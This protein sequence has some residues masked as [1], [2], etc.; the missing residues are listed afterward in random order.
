MTVI[1]IERTPEGLRQ[2]LAAAAAR[3]WRY[4]LKVAMKNG[5]SEADLAYLREQLAKA[6]AEAEA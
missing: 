5:A 1:P 2:S 4:V 3:S 6:E